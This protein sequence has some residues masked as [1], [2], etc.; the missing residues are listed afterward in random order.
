MSSRSTARRRPPGAARSDAELLADTSDAPESFAVFYRRHVDA[1]VRPCALRGLDADTAADVVAETFLDALR[2]RHR[3]RPQR[4]S[5]RLWLLTIASRRIV[6][7][8]RGRGSARRRD[9]RLRT[10]AIVLSQADRHGYAELELRQGG[11]GLDALADLPDVQRRAV[12]A[13]VLDDRD[14]GDIAR[15]L[16]LSEPATRQHVSRGLSALRRRLEDL[17]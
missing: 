15:A 2:G 3:Y 12:A 11:R 10:E 6:D 4:Q 13:R 17:R 9:R 8:H 16:G 5:A 1:L 7:L 14:Y